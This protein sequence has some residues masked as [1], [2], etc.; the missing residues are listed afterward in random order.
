VHLTD[1][2]R[3]ALRTATTSTTAELL[4]RLHAGLEALPGGAAPDVVTQ[5]GPSASS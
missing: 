1:E 5:R 4:S 2:A 3:E